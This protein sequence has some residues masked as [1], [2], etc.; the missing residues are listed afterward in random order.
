ML[1]TGAVGLNMYELMYAVA[2]KWMYDYSFPWKIRQVVFVCSVS[3]NIAQGNQCKTIWF[4]YF[5][6][7]ISN[8]NSVYATLL[9]SLEPFNIR[10]I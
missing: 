4:Q 3:L 2:L 6:K 5:N 8:W 10:I 7:A 9:L 1:A